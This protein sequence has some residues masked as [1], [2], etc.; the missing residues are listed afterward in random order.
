MAS[1]VG[2]S[3]DA[4]RRPG[5]VVAAGVTACLLAGCGSAASPAVPSAGQHPA[6]SI[7][8]EPSRWLTQGQRVQVVVRGFPAHVRVF[9]SECARLTGV[10]PGGCGNPPA[11]QPFVS[12][13]RRML[14]TDGRGTATG[15]FVVQV[16][17]ETGPPGSR[18]A[19]CWPGCTMVATTGGLGRG[20]AVVAET[21]IRFGQR[22]RPPPPSS[23]VP[24]TAPFTVLSRIGVP[25]RAWQL[26]AADG[27]LYCLSVRD[28]SGMVITRVDPAAGRAGPSRRVAQATAMG[29]GGGLLWTA[30]RSPSPRPGRPML[31]ALDP[32]TLA[33]V[34]TVTVPQPPGW[35]LSGI[36]Y[37]G[38]LIWVAGIH[39][40]TAVNPATA[41]VAA[42]VP[43]GSTGYFTGV[44]APPG[45]TVL[46]S[47][48]GS[49]GG[50]L[51]AI[52]A[53]NPR[54]GAVLA[55]TKGPVGGAAGAQ[56][57]A[58]TG[59]AW[60]AIPTGLLGTYVKV[61]EHG[62]RLA[63]IPPREH[64]VFANGISVYLAGR[65]LWILD[66]MSGS[67]ACASDATG[68][69][70]AAVYDTAMSVSDLAVLAPD[71]LAMPINGK[72]VIARPRP[73]CGP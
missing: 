54:T 71:R 31:L 6:A 68:R 37:A 20:R 50:G 17:A 60:L 24:A 33:V 45:G 14:I 55:G 69:I 36:A 32:V 52:Q 38:G 53:R 2:G 10:S 18:V 29:F 56:I 4:A 15:S 73:A 58:A 26:L 5:L 7:T 28:N 8:V 34:H 65:R 16:V 30:G 9:V 3:R 63:E 1:M 43:L 67:I 40:L 39:A 23:R 57:A 48:E 44:A 12:T 49:P 41:R 27:T 51:I 25:G 22:H 35:G 72:I 61:S 64:H 47:T 46:W 42:T 66:G 11:S 59:H 13:T 70:L 19:K 21:V 62:G